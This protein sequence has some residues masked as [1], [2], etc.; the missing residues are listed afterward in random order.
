MKLTFIGADHEVTGSCHLLEA[1]GFNILVD[2]GMEQGEDVF[3]NVPLPVAP[4][5]IDFVLLTHAHIDHSGLIPLLAARGFSGR[6]LATK[7]TC[8]LCRIML[9]DSAHIQEFEAE[10]RNRKGQRE[11]REPY[12]PL[13]TTEDAERALT[14]FESY[15]Y[16]NICEVAPGIK[17][18]FTDVGH[19]LGSSA[20]EVWAEEE[21]KTR[22]IVFSGDLGNTDQPILRDP[23]YVEEADYVLI[24]S[25]YGDRSHGGRID[26][27]PA[28]AS[29]IQ[30]TFDRGGNVVIPSFAVGRT[31][32]MLYFIRQIKEQGLVS[33]HDGFEV[34]VDSPLA[35]SA[36]TI[37][38]QNYMDCYDEEA[39]ELISRGINP[40]DFPGLRTATS[41]DESKAINFDKRP[42]VIISASGMCE[43]GRI[44]H[45]LK[46]NLWREEST[47]LFV[48]YQSVG[49][50]GRAIVDGAKQVS[51]F[52]EKIA[53]NAEVT[54]LPG[55][56]G[57]ADREGLL[58]W[59]AGFKEKPRR[60][61]VVH[62]EDEVTTLFAQ[63]LRE[64]L[65]WQA[66]APYSGTQY[67]L[68]TGK[69]L[70]EA[71]PVPIAKKE[72]A[73]GKTS[74]GQKATPYTRLENAL[75]RLAALVRASR[76]LA[77][78]DMGKLA[79][80]ILGI[81]DKWERK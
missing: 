9:L 50:L 68:L 65:G 20:I 63:S 59:A 71:S 45:H 56:S 42:K 54:V 52:G 51:L 11:G 12:V 32:E 44:K 43:A 7:A 39:Q 79:D 46:H 75:D 6:I 13:Y 72:P 73:S 8:D 17:V 2:Y 4:A 40:L 67:D 21:G 15:D 31:Q 57:H 25:T 47:I 81:V 30:R 49:T 24:E 26:Y 36:T 5:D 10:W 55:V 66:V 35:I 48:G 14:L 19:L 80:Q 69:C 78:K 64:E 23:E 37:F 70:F 62:G 28:L 1:A 76:H 77:N 27:V 33:G 53:V 74:S 41:A 29:V 38:G 16:G 60:C 61:F 34:Y 3:E 22:K 58:A 18:R